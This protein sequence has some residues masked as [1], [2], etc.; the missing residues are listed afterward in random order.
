MNKQR[1][2]KIISKGKFNFVVWNGVVGWGLL[3][4]VLYS[5]IQYFLNQ[6]TSP[7]QLLVSFVAFPIGGFFWGLWVWPRLVRKHLKEKNSDAKL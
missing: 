2:G 6:G 3:T 1:L 4:A 5:L 7:I